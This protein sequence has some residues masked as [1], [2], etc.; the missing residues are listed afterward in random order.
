MMFDDPAW[1]EYED[2]QDRLYEE[3]LKEKESELS[4]Q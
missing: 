4:P 2:E 1:M 3:W